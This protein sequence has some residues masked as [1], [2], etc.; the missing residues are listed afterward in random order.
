MANI[1]KRLKRLFSTGVIIR[2]VGGKKL[3]VMDTDSIQSYLSNAYRD[4]YSRIFSTAY[5]GNT[6]GNQYGLNMAYQTQR[7]MLFREYDIM[8][9]DPILHCIFGNTEVMTLKGPISIQELT[10]LYPNG[11]NFE[12]WSWDKEK[13]QYTIGQAHHPRKTDIKEVIE[14]V[15]DNGKILKCTDNHRLMLINGSYKEAGNCK[16]GDALMPFSYKTTKDGKYIKIRKSTGGY[17]PAH[18]Y[19]FE[20]VL[21][22]DVQGKHIHHINHNT[23]DNRVCNLQIMTPEEHI[24]YHGKSPITKGKRSDATKKLWKDSAY[25]KKV[26]NA[27][28]IW[29]TSEDGH[30][31][32]VNQATL[33]GKKTK[34]RWKNDR[35]YANR[36]KKIFS[37][38]LK[39]LWANPDWSRWKR[40]Q[41]SKIAK[42]RYENDAEFRKLLQRSGKENGRYNH[43][44]STQSILIKGF[45]YSTLVEFANDPLFKNVFSKNKRG[46]CQFINNRLKE[47]GFSGWKNY[48]QTYQYTNHKITEIR[49]NGEV[50]DVFDLTVD[51][52][53]N[54]AI[55][56]GII[57]S[58][59]ALDIYADECTVH[60]EN[61]EILTIECDDDNIKDI[62][63]NLFY[64]ILNIE[65]NLYSWVRNMCKY[66]DQFLFIEINEEYGV[67]NIYPLS[68]YDTV[69]VE[70]EDPD[71]PRYVYFQTMGMSGQKVKMEQY[72]VMH[73]RLMTDSN[74]LPYGKCL[75]GNTLVWTPS[76]QVKIKDLNKG[77]A[78][79]SFDP[80]DGK[81]VSTEVINWVKTG[82]KQVYELQTATQRIKATENHSFLTP[83]GEYKAL[84]DLTTDDYIILPNKV[85]GD[86]DLLVSLLEDCS[87]IPNRST[88]QVASLEDIVSHLPEFIRFFG[89]MLGDGWIEN[90]SVSFSL[91]NRL[92]KSSKY[93]EFVK[94]FGLTTNILEENST[95][96]Y[97]KIYSSQFMHLLNKCG[98]KTGTLKKTVPLW[99]YELPQ[100]LLQE[101]LLGFADADGC[102]VQNGFQIS[103]IN[104][105]LIYELHHIAQ[106]AG[107]NTAKPSKHINTKKNSWGSY[108]KPT[109]SFRFLSTH[110]NSKVISNSI[111]YQRIWNISPVDVVDVYDIQVK[112]EY[113]NFIA[114]G[115]VVHNS[116]MEGAR[117]TWKQLTLM[118]D[119][120]LIHRIMRAP[121]KRVI[122]VDIGNTPP[123]EVDAFMQKMADK[124]KKTP[125]MDP[126]TGD[127]NLRYNMMNII[128]DFYLPVRSKN[129]ATEI[130][131]LGGLEFN[132]IEDIEYLRNR[133]MAALKIPKSFLGY[134]EAIG[135]KL[136]LAAEDVRFARTIERIQKIIVAELKKLAIVHLFCQGFEDEELVSFN[137]HLTLPSTIY[138][139][140][141]LNIWKERV[142]FATDAQN[143]Q[144]V[145][146]EWIYKHMFNFSDTEV[147]E[148]RRLVV[149]DTKRKYRLAQLEQG[150]SDPAKYGYPQ[151][152]EPQEPAEGAPAEGEEQPV[153]EAKIGRP[154]T[155]MQYG[156]DSHPEG[157]DPIG[158]DGRY[159][160]I[161]HSKQ[162]IRIP[163]KKSPLSLEIAGLKTF[164]GKKFNKP[165][166]VSSELLSENTKTD[167]EKDKGTFLD[168]EIVEDYYVDNE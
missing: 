127:Y 9:S 84:K 30:N 151:D 148:Q 150:A 130:T 158:L 167:E 140:E 145:S 18:R 53:E 96:A 71:N 51:R 23:R 86:V 68:V 122:K 34:E 75:E 55:K 153:G 56:Q 103:G 111:R 24:A 126:A 64:D 125:F 3:K 11:E 27:I 49:R 37:D 118:E 131:N 57:I 43:N 112:S 105:T 88:S 87:F 7:I 104:K 58:N 78:V 159:D 26:I 1:F 52:F 12:V 128:E 154:K 20:N 93:L 155:G 95:R 29:Q 41:Q 147:E 134:E 137:L 81:I 42:N 156:Q 121:E 35:K 143:L 157:R 82:R 138:E 45:E 48:K 98:F 164:L 163:R 106:L 60:N 168:K 108:S 31:C 149:E 124:M 90:N 99:V 65:F 15:L 152:Q 109:Y 36:T 69:R 32:L 133:M 19:I 107:Y 117:R 135:G 70:N 17:T 74:F 22:E 21:E 47:A 40:E 120:M 66:G 92:D 115:I 8:D 33:L 63:E 46:I 28:K 123:N 10:K 142:Q 89:F 16:V 110:K 6:W 136:T 61:H 54:F 39:S 4:R 160:V 129:D 76:G 59:S 116:M 73:L 72:E 132:S 144:L 113:N 114:N 80:I 38:H 62:L 100:N 101:F 139:Q 79:Y 102:K 77:D 50:A 44:I 83:S 97:C 14:I 119:A 85:D 67:T 91:G 166:E 25:R 13:C 5:Y 165:P 141:K 2:H 161:K 94:H 146:S 162:D